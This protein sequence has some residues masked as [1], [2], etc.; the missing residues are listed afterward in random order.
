LGSPSS[1]YFEVLDLYIIANL[2]CRHRKPT[3]DE[4]GQPT[5]PRKPLSAVDENFGTMF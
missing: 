5:S 4:N 2:R 1:Q 3:T